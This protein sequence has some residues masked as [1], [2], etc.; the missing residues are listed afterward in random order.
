MTRVAV[1]DDYQD[2]ALQMADWNVLPPDTKVQVFKDHLSNPEAVA[3]RLKDFDIV[4]AMRERTAFLRAAIHGPGH[5]R[6][7]VRSCVSHRLPL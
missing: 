6:A 2:V 7:S 4:V 5:R 1:L 3:E